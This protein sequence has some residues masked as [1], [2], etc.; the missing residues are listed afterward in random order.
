MV[1][2]LIIIG[3]PP[4]AFSQVTHTLEE[5]AEGDNVQVYRLT[6]SP[7][8]PPYP[9]LKHR[10]T[11]PLYKTVPGN[12]VTHLLR[13]F[14]ENSLDSPL[15]AARRDFGDEF[16]DW[17]SIEEFPIDTLPLEKLQKACKLFDSYVD[18]HIDRATQ[19]RFIDWG[20]AEE[21][22]N[23]VQ[24]I[25]FLLPSIQQTRS[26][27]RVLSLRTRLAI[28]QGDFDAAVR[29]MRMNYRLAESV[30]KMKF[31]VCSLVGIAEVGIANRN[32]LDFIAAENSPN[33]YW[34][35]TE[36]PD[37]LVSIRDAVRLEVSIGLRLIPDFDEA[38]TADHTPQEWARIVKQAAADLSE[39]LLVSGQAGGTNNKAVSDAVAFG[40]SLAGYKSAKERLIAG[41]MDRAKVEAM[42]V[43]QVIMID[44][45]RTYR[46][47]ADRLE[48]IFNMRT[49]TV[50]K[51]LGEF[52]EELQ[53][54]ARQLQF[55]AILASYCLPAVQQVRNASNRVRRENSVLITLESLR[56]HLAETGK[57]PSSLDELNL[58]SPP[59]PF[60]GKPLEYELKNGVGII[61]CPRSDGAPI[62]YRY[63]VSI[64]Q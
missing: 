38:E 5:N 42:S 19:C 40:V 46:D 60:T 47:L 45:S 17:M 16:Y 2:V 32:M 37:P 62:P 56:N 14:G 43:G 1:A 39:I 7:S 49:Y 11:V 55:G 35:L 9:V 20:L 36:L 30:S 44:A 27:S 18:N 24:S 59:N 61:T 10:L 3:T 21:E 48:A 41:G 28:A 26:V 50:D 54:S 64:K 53:R 22:L 31:F 58:P 57:L 34:S 51:V 33:L 23:G 6:I 63:E 12:A 15:K 52:E 29:Q 4:E 25:N 13:S 8:K